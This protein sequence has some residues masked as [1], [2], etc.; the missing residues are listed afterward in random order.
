MPILLGLF[1]TLTGSRIGRW[2]AMALAVTAMA[3]LVLLAAFRRGKDSAALEQAAAV[4][5]AVVERLTVEHD[6]AS[7]PADERRRRLA[8]WVRAVLLMM[9]L[10]QCTPIQPNV[11]CYGWQPIWPTSLDMSVI[12][13]SLV[14]QLLSHNEYGVRTCGW[15]IPEQ[16]D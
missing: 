14:T 6:I 8:Q 12:S 5:A 9:V 15:R 11:T 7:L 4:T 16:D 2:V 13:D 1:T 10:T 3:G